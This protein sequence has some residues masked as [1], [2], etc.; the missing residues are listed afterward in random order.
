[1]FSTSFP[2]EDVITFP[3]TPTGNV[4]KTIHFIID[5]GTEHE[6]EYTNVTSVSGKQLSQ[7]FP[8]QSHGSH[9]LDV[10]FNA[11]INGE[12]VKSNTLHYEFISID[13]N[14]T[15]TIIVSP[16]TATEQQQYSSVVIPYSVYDPAGVET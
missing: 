9:T 15:D 14:G 13:A 5:K 3:Y 4:S 12:P 7:T 10:Y 1:M 2:F 6:V 16:F 8:A 11:E